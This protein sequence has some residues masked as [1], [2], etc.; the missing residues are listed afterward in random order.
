MESGRDGREKFGRPKPKG[1]HVGRTNAQL[2]R[3]KSFM[4]VK[5]KKKGKNKRSYRDKQKA[6][7]N[8][9]AHQKKMK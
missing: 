6:L 3:N 5:Q 2:A 8:Y 7:Q 4:M 9:F 1:S